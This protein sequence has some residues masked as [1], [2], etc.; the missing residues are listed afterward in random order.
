MTVI[1]EILLNHLELK[2][3]K[4]SAINEVLEL[5]EICKFNTFGS[6]C[7]GA[8][9][10]C[11]V[12]ELYNKIHGSYIKRQNLSEPERR[13]LYKSLI[14]LLSRKDTNGVVVAGFENLDQIIL[15]VALEQLRD[16]M[17]G[18]IRG[19]RLNNAPNLEQLLTF[20]RRFLKSFKSKDTS[21]FV[22]TRD[23]QTSVFNDELADQ[24]DFKRKHMIH[25]KIDFTACVYLGQGNFTWVRKEWNEEETNEILLKAESIKR[26][27]RQTIYNDES[28]LEFALPEFDSEQRIYLNRA[29][30]NDGQ[31]IT[32]PLTPKKENYRTMV[33]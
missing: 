9:G 8:C 1:S 31:D 25:L 33:L 20:C 29:L 3:F 23:T 7:T 16:A 27:L 4:R 12:R 2:I 30:K 6:K 32:K 5:K 19:V 21:R 13:S 18:H 17:A 14:Q 15:F 26:K 11:D 10:I 22:E 28:L 24:K